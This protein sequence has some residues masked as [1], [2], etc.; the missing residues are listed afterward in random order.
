MSK[1]TNS[2]F[3]NSFMRSNAVSEVNSM[4]FTRAFSR[5]R[6]TLPTT[7]ICAPLPLETK[8]SAPSQLSGSKNSPF[9]QDRT[10]PGI[11]FSNFSERLLSI[12]PHLPS[13]ASPQ[14]P[15]N[16][17]PSFPRRKIAYVSQPLN[18]FSRSMSTTRLERK[19]RGAT[20]ARITS[21]GTAAPITHSASIVPRLISAR[22]SEKASSNDT[23]ARA[24]KARLSPGS[25]RA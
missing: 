3:Y 13:T 24:L 12:G 20:V 4:F 21:L 10:P 14:N 23:F 9:H 17:S 6:F 5:A 16:C 22:V 7:K 25:L 11:S 1:M 18:E 8:M 19:K 2:H 15:G